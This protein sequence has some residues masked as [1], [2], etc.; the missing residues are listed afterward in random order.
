MSHG[1]L[2]FRLHRIKTFWPV[3]DIGTSYGSVVIR[4]RLLNHTQI[5]V[6]KGNV[7]ICLHLHVYLVITPGSVQHGLET[8]ECSFIV[9]KLLEAEAHLLVSV[10]YHEVILIFLRHVS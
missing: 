9:L 4:A 7:L 3:V 5:V 6:L 2:C 8:H 10:H 1:P